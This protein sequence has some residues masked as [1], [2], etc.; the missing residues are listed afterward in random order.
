MRLGAQSELSS[1]RA[2]A[3]GVR[4]ELTVACAT[5]VFKTAALGLYATPPSLNY[6]AND[7][8]EAAGF[9]RKK[10]R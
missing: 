2:V 7:E 9:G 4:F 5:A 6:T 10:R 1:M 3:E 8:F